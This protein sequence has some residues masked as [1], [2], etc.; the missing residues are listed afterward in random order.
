MSKKY[1]VYGIGNALVDLEFK[2]NDQFLYDH[3]VQKGLMTLV[4]EDTQFRLIGAID[5]GDLNLL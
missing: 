1:D 4:D 2:V 3:K 5:S